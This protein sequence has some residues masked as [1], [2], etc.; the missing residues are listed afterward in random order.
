MTRIFLHG[1]ESSNQG[2][3]A[4]FFRDMYPDMIIPTFTG[5]LQE[6]MSRLNEILSGA[7]DIRMVGSS[8]GG[9]MGTVFTMENESAVKRLVLLAPA[10]HVLDAA[11][12]SIHPISLPVTVYHGSKD[13]VIPIDKVRRVAETYFLDLD[14][15]TVVDDHMLHE[16]FKAIDWEALLD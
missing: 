2:T 5:D 4:V 12:E 7:S 9:L 1:L 15:H 8:F 10:I 11:P 16:T 13:E 3:K 6:R 14:F